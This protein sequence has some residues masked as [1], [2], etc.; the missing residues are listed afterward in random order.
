MTPQ[1]K[2]FIKWLPLN[3]LTIIIGVIIANY[4]KS[5]VIVINTSDKYCITMPKQD[6][7]YVRK[8][9]KTI[10]DTNER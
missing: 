7:D 10:G 5:E 6:L 9:S 8:N 2:N 3:M 4:A 1:H